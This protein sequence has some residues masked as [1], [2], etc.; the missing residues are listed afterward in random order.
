V[1]IHSCVGNSFGAVLARSRRIALLTFDD[2]AAGGTLLGRDRLAGALL[3]D[4][5]DQ[6]G[7]V[8]VLEFVGLEPCNY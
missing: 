2:V 6:R 7:L 3:V 1:I 4:E 5:V 8:V